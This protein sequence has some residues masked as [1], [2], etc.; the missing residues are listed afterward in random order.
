M[1]APKRPNLAQL[2]KQCAIWNAAY[3]IGTTVSFEFIRGEG[4]TYRGKSKTEAQVMGGHTA[5][6]WLEGK[7]GCLNLDHCTAVAGDDNATA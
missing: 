5:V 4:E 1:P 2:E 3:P 6:I 7:S